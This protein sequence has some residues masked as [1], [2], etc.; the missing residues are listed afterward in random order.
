[1][2][3]YL[4]TVRRELISNS[5]KVN[6]EGARGYLLSVL[7]LH[8]RT[9]L[10]CLAHTSVKSALTL[11]PCCRSGQEDEVQDGAEGGRGAGQ[12]GAQVHLSP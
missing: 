11:V 2:L 10:T 6:S 1:M 4:P 7:S 3:I 5:Y 8:C 12:E 9:S